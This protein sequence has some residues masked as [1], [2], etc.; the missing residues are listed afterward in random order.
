MKNKFKIV[1]TG[2]SGQVAYAFLFRLLSANIFPENTKIE[3]C[4]LDLD[5]ALQKCYG[6]QMELEDCLFPNLTKVICTSN[7][8]EAMIDA[9]LAVLIGAIP[10]KSAA[11][12]RNDLLQANASIFKEQAMALN[13]FAARDVKVL[14]VGNPCNTNCLVAIHNAKDLPRE[15]FYAMM[16]L[17]ENR[18]RYQLAN[19]AG[20]SISSVE[21]MIIWGNHSNSMYPDFYNAKLNGKPVIETLEE[22]WLQTE[23]ITHIRNRGADIIAARGMSS[24]ASAAN[25][26]LNTID[27]M[28]NKQRDDMFSLGCYSKGEYGVE[29]DLVFSFPCLLQNEKINI[30]LGIEH[31]TLFA[32]EQLEK[33]ISELRNERDI[34][35]KLGFV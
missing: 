7:I 1:V 13:E 23:F 16:L 15:N 26:A 35:Y 8:N 32:K 31:N 20:V 24:G 28:F 10:R 21:N 11:T 12:S 17:D 2:A 6:V 9:N 29:S 4:L 14:V 19:K 30:V 3:L 5:S 33:T 22:S 18:A 34:V 25:A 27:R